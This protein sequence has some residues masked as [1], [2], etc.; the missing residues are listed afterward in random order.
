MEKNFDKWNE[1]KKK[2]H[3]E[4]IAPFYHE[5]EIWWCSIGVNVGFEQDGTGNNFDR[6]IVVIRG[7]NK[8]TFFGI[9]LTGKKKVG[10]YYFY[11]GKI[12]DR[13]ATAVLSQVRLLDSKRL[14]RKIGL[15]DEV[16]FE[17]LKLALIKA[18]FSNE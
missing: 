15:L 9:G 13:D 2:L 10:K 7:F 6:P 8:S 16:Q 1:S 5:R 12:E 18:L 17:E 14:V 4:N 11:L 3:G